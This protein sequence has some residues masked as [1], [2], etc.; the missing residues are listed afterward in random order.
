MQ[1]TKASIN[2]TQ[3]ER[4]LNRNHAAISRLML[5]VVEVKPLP[6]KAAATRDR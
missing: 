6:A 1:Q 2:A 4:T 3:L 5:T